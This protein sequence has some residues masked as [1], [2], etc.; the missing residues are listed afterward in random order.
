[1]S[2]FPLISIIVSVYNSEKF[3]RGKLEDLF[4]QTLIEQ[5]EVII[6]NSGSLQNEEP[7]ILEFARQHPNIVYIKTPQRETIYQAWN[8]GIRAAR[9]QFIT[10]SNTDDRL[11]TIT[12]QVMSDF[13]LFHP[14]ISIVYADQLYSFSPNEILTEIKEP[15][16]MHFSKFSQL[17]LLDICIIGSQPMW[18]KNL[19]D[20]DSLYFNE[21]YEIAGDW[22]FYLRVASQYKIRKMNFISGSFY[23]PPN[24]SNKEAQNFSLTFYEG[25]KISLFYVQKFINSMS[26]FKRL[27]YILWL[28]PLVLSPF[29]LFRVMH[30]IYRSFTREHV[31]NHEFVYL[32][33]ALCL[34]QANL[35][36][37]AIYSAEKFLRYN[38]SPRLAALV[39]SSNKRTDIQLPDFSQFC[40]N[41]VINN[42]SS[43]L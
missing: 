18:R 16:K 13:L 17:R 33:T 7:I 19:H 41:I 42:Q 4:N 5:C 8:R 23:K 34:R 26:P 32:M 21:S 39:A 11:N 20:R 36:R 37:L 31:L 30:K 1:M 27:C 6:I 3:I 25:N 40:K 10:N 22:D 12:L 29:Y 14:D 9:G 28:L 43:S 15:R 24:K 38:P 2:S 35:P